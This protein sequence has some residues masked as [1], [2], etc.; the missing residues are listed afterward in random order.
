MDGATL[1]MESGRPTKSWFIGCL[2]AGPVI[3]YLILIQRYAYN[4]P[5]LDDYGT[6]ISHALLPAGEQVRNWFAPHN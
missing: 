6:V 1:N 5:F 3:V 2:L 4:F